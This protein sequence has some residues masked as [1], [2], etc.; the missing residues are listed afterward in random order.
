MDKELL[1]GN[2]EEPYHLVCAQ[3]SKKIKLFRAATDETSL[4]ASYQKVMFGAAI[5]V[6]DFGTCFSERSL[7]SG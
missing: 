2:S 3:G 1:L 7:L 6:G 4:R 5:K